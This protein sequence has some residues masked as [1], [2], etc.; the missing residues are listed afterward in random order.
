MTEPRDGGTAGR[1]PAPG[2]TLA[3]ARGDVRDGVASIEHFLQVLASRRVGPRVLS[4]GIPEVLAGCTPL[5]TALAS[6]ARS[7]AAELASDTAGLD[8]VTALLAHA[9]SRL[10]ELEAALVAHASVS[11]DARERLALEAVVRRVAA[12]LGAVVRLVDLLGAAVTSETT[13]IDLDDALAQRRARP[14]PGT[15]PVLVSVDVRVSELTV[16]D[17]RL[18]LELLD[19][20]VATVVRAGVPAPRIAV[21]LGPDGFPLFTVAEPPPGVTGE[22]TQAIHVVLREELPREADVV[23]AAARHAG[24]DLA[25]AGDRRTVTIAL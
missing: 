17:A 23:R 25:I 22:R 19:H 2:D 15:T 12:D 24:I 6:L 16:G 11:L 9:T 20:A 1:P 13:T 14:R 7:L 8:A 21:D 3:I 10:H 4:R 5:H 18:V